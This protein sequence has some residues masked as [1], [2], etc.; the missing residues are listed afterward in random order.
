MTRRAL[1]VRPA[2]FASCGPRKATRSRAA[3]PA[4]RGWWAYFGVEEFSD[5]EQVLVFCPARSERG[6]GQD[7]RLTRV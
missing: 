7:L 3:F 4:A 6:F 1:A 2:P 5:E